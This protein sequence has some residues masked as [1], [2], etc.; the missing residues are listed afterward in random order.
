MNTHWDKAVTTDFLQEDQLF[1]TWQNDLKELIV[2][3][4]FKP[5]NRNCTFIAQ[6]IFML[7]IS[8]HPHMSM[9]NSEFLGDVHAMILLMVPTDVSCIMCL[10][11]LLSVK[12]TPAYL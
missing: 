2:C 4:F 8:L 7:K 3:V 6:N 1:L 5:V 10:F 12:I 11:Y 9:K